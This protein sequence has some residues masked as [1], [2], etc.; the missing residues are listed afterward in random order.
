L[1]SLLLLLVGHCPVSQV[2]FHEKNFG[3]MAF[4]ELN[5]EVLG[6]LWLMACMFE[7]GGRCPF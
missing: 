6:S 5:S 1:N 3:L 2:V 4:W 7:A